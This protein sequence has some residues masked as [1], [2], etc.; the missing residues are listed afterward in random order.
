MF[1]SIFLKPKVNIVLVRLCCFLCYRGMHWY[2]IKF[3]K[4]VNL[5]S[6]LQWILQ[7][8]I[9][10]YCKV[11][12][13]HMMYRRGFLGVF[14]QGWWEGMTGGVCGHVVFLPSEMSICFGFFLFYLM[15]IE[16]CCAPSVKTHTVHGSTG[17][18]P[19]LFLPC[20]V[21]TSLLNVPQ[22][23]VWNRSSFCSLHFMP[24]LSPA[25]FCCSS[26]LFQDLLL[27]TAKT[28]CCHVTGF[29]PSS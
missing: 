26:Y 8:Q 23:T 1:L 20:L 10:L 15:S 9:S 27:I 14:G 13:K 16:L 2:K 24:G 12:I 28:F 29:P 5:H 7:L 17:A 6:P 19:L 11:V 21:V 18:L 4:K 22:P 3:S 25:A